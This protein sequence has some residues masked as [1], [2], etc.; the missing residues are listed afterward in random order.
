M[1]IPTNICF[2]PVFMRN[3]NIGGFEIFVGVQDLHS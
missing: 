1:A 2:K 3:A